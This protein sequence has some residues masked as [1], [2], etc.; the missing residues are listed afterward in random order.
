MSRSD[1]P[2]LHSA[3][4]QSLLRRK[5]VSPREAIESLLARIEQVEPKI[6]AYLSIDLDPVL[7]E[8]EKVDVGLPLAVF[9]L[10]INVSIHV[11]VQP[12]P[13]V[14]IIIHTSHLLY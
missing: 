10:E 8:A 14:S 13:C 5:E 4:L 11:I 2:A 6:D 1:L 3:E 9:P 12:L 7:K